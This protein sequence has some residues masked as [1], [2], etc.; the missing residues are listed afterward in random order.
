MKYREPYEFYPIDATI[1]EYTGVSCQWTGNMGARSWI[2]RLD[3][4]FIAENTGFDGSDADVEFANKSVAAG[5][6]FG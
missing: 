1:T 4:N 6:V 5:V 2:A 3:A